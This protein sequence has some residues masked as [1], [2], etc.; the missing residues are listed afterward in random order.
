MKVSLLHNVQHRELQFRD[1]RAKHHSVWVDPPWNECASAEQYARFYHTS[2][3]E[4]LFAARQGFDAVALNEHHQNAF[5]GLPNPN[6]IGAIL[7]HQTKNLPVAIFQLGSTL[8]TTAPP[9]RL[10]EEYA[11]IDLLSEGRLMAGMPVGTPM[12]VSLCYGVPPLEHRERYRESH[13]LIIKAWTSREPFAWNGKY[14]QLP[15]VNVW[16]RPLQTPHPPVWVPGTGSTSTWDFAAS[17]DY[18]YMVLTAFSGKMG[19]ADSARLV[20]GFQERAAAHGRDA[21]PFRSGLALLPVV[22]E[23]MAQCERDFFPHVDYFF[24]GALHIAPQHLMPPGTPVVWR[25]PAAVAAAPKAPVDRKSLNPFDFAGW[26]FKDYVDNGVIVAGSEKDVADQIEDL[27]KKFR[28]GHLMV[29]M[30][31]GSTPKELAMDSIGRFARSVIPRVRP[32][33]EDEGWT[34]H[35]WPERLRGRRTD[36]PTAE[37]HA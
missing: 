12:D 6:I 31:I 3:E 22:G 23:S 37:A 34:N 4:I 30:Q 19:I 17:H 8:P 25:D 27:V 35:W 13:D 1:F 20:G 14:F 7:A 28:C 33:F 18:G 10:A 36:A 11:M 21:N 32:L 26:K 16:P 29:C 2:I 24:N 9:N 15:C 5:G